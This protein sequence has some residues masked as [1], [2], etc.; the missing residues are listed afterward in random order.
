MGSIEVTEQFPL[1]RLHEI[2]AWW[3]HIVNGA[4]FFRTLENGNKIFMLRLETVRMN[5]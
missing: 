3:G 4:L 1:A 5:G 2:A